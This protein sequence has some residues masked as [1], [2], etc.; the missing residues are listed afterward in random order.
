MSAANR[1][2]LVVGE[3]GPGYAS[4]F[5]AMTS[6]AHDGETAATAP[7]SHQSHLHG[8]IERLGLGL[9]RQ[10]PHPT[11]NRSLTARGADNPE[12]DAQLGAQPAGSDHSPGAH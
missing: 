8:L 2:R 3:L 4:P 11:R 6:R 5:H 7:I 10:Q 12:A 1:Y 9:T